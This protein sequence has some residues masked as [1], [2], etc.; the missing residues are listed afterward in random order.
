MDNTISLPGYVLRWIC[1]IPAGLVAAVLVSF[2]I[3]WFVMINLGGASQDPIIEIQDTATLENV[4][5]FLQALLA[6]LACIFFGAKTAPSHKTATA[7]V[8]AGT[9]LI[10]VPALAYWLNTSGGNIHVEHGVRQ[11]I[12]HA[13][14]AAG[15][16][17][18][19]F[20]G[21]QSVQGKTSGTA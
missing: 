16:I 1:V 5:R 9:I 21:R 8:L 18:L 19:T 3:H 2:P 17:Y 6:P 13:V 12:A 7:V 14:G 15:A 4:E 20:S 10:G 11:T